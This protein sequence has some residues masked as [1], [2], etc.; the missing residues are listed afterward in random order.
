MCVHF[1]H[2]N[3]G[4]HAKQHGLVEAAIKF[5]DDHSVD[6]F[7][8]GAEV[9]DGTRDEGDEASDEEDDDDEL[10]DDEWT[11]HTNFLKVIKFIKSTRITMIKLSSIE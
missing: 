1:W 5:E 2:A 9:D 10:F 7:D 11:H 4:L 3:K 6:Y 8:E